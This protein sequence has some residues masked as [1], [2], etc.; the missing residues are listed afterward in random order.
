MSDN[1]SYGSASPIPAGSGRCRNALNVDEKAKAVVNDKSLQDDDNVSHNGSDEGE[2][3]VLGVEKEGEAN[4]NDP[5][6]KILNSNIA[7]PYIIWDNSTR[8]SLHNRSLWYTP[9]GVPLSRAELLDFVDK[10]RN[11][12]EHSV[13]AGRGNAWN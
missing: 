6:L 13:G 7:D 9:K 5:V 10:H 12:N 8:Y 11:L 3:V 4:R 1:D 2:V